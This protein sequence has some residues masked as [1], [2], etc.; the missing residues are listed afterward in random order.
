LD[1]SEWAEGMSGI[2]INAKVTVL[3][4]EGGVAPL[5]DTGWPVFHGGL[6]RSARLALRRREVLAIPHANEN[7]PGA[8][9]PSPAN[10]L[11]A[12]DAPAVR[13]LR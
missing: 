1:R 10:G 3:A 6:R 5:A 13:P 9:A 2:G 8:P 11:S 4:P 7:R 12:T